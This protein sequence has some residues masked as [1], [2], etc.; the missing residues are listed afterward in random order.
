MACSSTAPPMMFS[1]LAGG[2]AGT[3]IDVTLFPLD[4]LK[5]RCQAAGGFTKAGGFSCVYRGLGP[6]AIGAAPSAALFFATYETAKPQA[7]G[8]LG[9]EAPEVLSHGAAASCGESL[10]CVVRVPTEVVKTRMQ[11]GRYRSL[12]EASTTIMR[13]EGLRGFYTGYC[14]TLCREIPFALIQFPLYELLKTRWERS[15]GEPSPWQGA[16][17]GSVAGSVAAAITTPLD[18]ARTRLML[19]QGQ[20]GIASTLAAIY[21][22]GGVRAMC[23][24]SALRMSSMGLGGFVFFGIYETSLRLLT[25]KE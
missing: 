6:A 20:G 16:C 5:T 14:T 9:P 21:A 2:C 7:A 12:R 3:S 23:A 15:L 13:T 17:C 22:E 4:T 8:L 19:Q 24:G 11:T 10:A 25:G 18:V 1:L